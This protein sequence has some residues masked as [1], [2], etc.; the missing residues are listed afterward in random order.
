MVAQ[1]AKYSV[2]A[3][4]LELPP[5]KRVETGLQV[6]ARN[7]RRAECVKIIEQQR[8]INSFDCVVCT[9]H[10]RDDQEETMLLKLLRG[11][12]ISR[13][14]QARSWIFSDII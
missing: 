12:H 3:D 5:E 1:A 8:R 2:S 6:T 14:S 10:H 4:V 13:L 9:A 11:V 7:W